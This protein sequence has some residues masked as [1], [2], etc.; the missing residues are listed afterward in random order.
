MNK[1]KLVAFINQRKQTAF[2]EF[3]WF[4]R[5]KQ[6]SQA[7]TLT[8]KELQ[9][10]LLFVQSRKHAARDRA[11][12]LLMH[13]AGM[14]VGEVAA[15]R[16]G[17]VLAADGTIKH[18]IKLTAQQTKGSRSRAVVLSDKVRKE[19]QRYL[20]WRFDEKHL[21]AITYSKTELDKPLFK[22]QKRDGFT[23]NTLSY[24]FHMLYRA[25]GL[26]GAS[27]H[28]GRRHFLTSLSKRGVA[29]RTMME[30]AG[31][32]QAQTTM[33]YVDVTDDMKR[34]AVELI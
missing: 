16:I 14:R 21:I 7:R 2:N 11:M 15:T 19:L 30:L 24:H 22:T 23:A 4:K 20:Q 8:E 3:I 31:H 33:R 1:Q 27:S 10:F 28:S 6:M 5:K 13:W 29:L 32:R 17:D 18:E 9:L 12:T 34:A 26:D 25:A